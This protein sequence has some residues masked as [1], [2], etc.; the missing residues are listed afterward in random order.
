MSSPEA[1]SAS[2]VFGSYGFVAQTGEPGMP[3]RQV[4]RFLKRLAPAVQETGKSRLALTLDFLAK[5]AKGYS[6]SEYFS[7][8]LYDGVPPNYIPHRDYH[9]AERLLNPRITGVVGFS[10]WVQYNFF[11]ANGI[12][13]PETYGFVNGTRGV[14]NGTPFV[15]SSR[16]LCEQLRSLTLPTLV[17]MPP[18]NGQPHVDILLDIDE[19]GGRLHFEARGWRDIDGLLSG[20]EGEGAGILFQ[21]LL[22][23][24]QALGVFPP[25]LNTLRVITHIGPTGEIDIAACFLKIARTGHRIDNMHHGAVGA[26][27]DLSSGRLEK[28]FSGAGR[29]RFTHHPDT[30]APIEGFEVP[31]FAEAIALAKRAHPLLQSPSLI[32]WDVAVTDEGPKIIE[33]NSYVAF[34]TTQKGDHG[35][36]QSSIG[37]HIRAVLDR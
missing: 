28:G 30:G 7:V 31:F 5:R 13:Q 37:R 36:G 33:A 23:Q 2:S 17:K 27:V 34:W 10:K 26:H 16:T 14:L 24:H 9:A 6:I 25:A 15:P 8:P 1:L 29:T 4:D 12:P 3:P 21:E 19:A 11:K 22:N 20:P 32:G 35:L 18:V